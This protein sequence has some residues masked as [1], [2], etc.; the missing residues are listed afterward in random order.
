MRVEVYEFIVPV[1]GILEVEFWLSCISI[2]DIIFS[3]DVKIVI[4]KNVPIFMLE[5][6]HR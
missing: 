1:A 6:V 4:L 2:A 5:I 3:R